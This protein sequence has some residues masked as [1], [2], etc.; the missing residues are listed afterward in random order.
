VSGFTDKAFQRELAAVLAATGD[1]DGALA[2]AARIQDGD[3]ESWL[4]EWTA[5]GGEAWAAGRDLDAAAYYGAALALIDRT[6]GSV[7]AR[8][9]AARRRDCW[10]RAILALGGEPLHDPPGVLSRVAVRPGPLLVI[11]HGGRLP[12]AHIGDAA[13][14]AGLHWMTFDDAP[15]STVADVMLARAD[16]TRLLLLG[17][18]HAP[19]RVI[20]ALASEHRF[21]AA[22]IEPM[23]DDLPSSLREA[24]LDGSREGFERELHLLGLFDPAAREALVRRGRRYDGEAS[25]YDIYAC[26]LG[27]PPSDLTTPLWIGDP[28]PWLRRWA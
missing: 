17:L 20:R 21:T 6:D 9:L 27:G 10:T 13:H 12:V 3:A 11:D 26:L 28:F 15:I 7:D 5:A 2:T 4:L 22:A 25:L 18:G 16:V 23:V 14:A 1:A 8:A 24:L 19:Y